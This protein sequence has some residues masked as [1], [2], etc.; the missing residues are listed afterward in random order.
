MWCKIFR[1]VEL[2]S[3]SNRKGALFGTFFTKN[4][5]ILGTNGDFDCDQKV[6]L[7]G[8]LISDGNHGKSQKR[9]NFLT[10]IGLI[11]D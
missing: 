4:G 6:F 11:Y 3:V 1:C 10:D 5:N 9:M 7:G 2:S 8:I